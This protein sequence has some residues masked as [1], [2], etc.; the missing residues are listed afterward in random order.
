MINNE[1]GSYYIEILIAI[2]LLS[3]LGSAILPIYTRFPRDIKTLVVRTR[4]SGMAEYVSEYLFRWANFDPASKP[5]PFE[6]YQD[7]FELEL[8][9][10]KRINRLLWAQSL[11]T[12][13]SYITDEYKASITFHETARLN[14]AVVK[15]VVWF[16]DNLDNVVGIGEPRQSFSVVLTEKRNP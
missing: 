11:L 7:D 13:T 5:V 16:D 6:F 14:S 12:E 9:G 2:T 8:S 1:S 10:E 3:F 4:L 15:V